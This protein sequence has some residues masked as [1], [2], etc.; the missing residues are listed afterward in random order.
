MMY[1]TISWI[2][3]L[4]E[5]DC[6]IYFTTLVYDIWYISTVSENGRSVKIF[7]SHVADRLD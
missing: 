4:G 5:H 3:R 6:G 2:I 7:I 1:N